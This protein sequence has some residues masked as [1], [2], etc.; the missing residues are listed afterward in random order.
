MTAGQKAFPVA[1]SQWKFHQQ[2]ATGRWL[3][4]LL[5]HHGK[6]A[7]DICLIR[8]VHTDAI[9]HD[10][11]IT[12]I[13]TGSEQPGRPC[14]GSWVTYGIGSENQNLPAFIVLISQG[15]GNKSDQPLF[16][17]LWGVGFLPSSYQGVKFRSQGDPVLFIKNPDGL[18]DSARREMLDTLKGLNQA[19]FES[20]GDPEIE[21]RIAQYEMALPD[22]GE[23]AGA[24]GHCARACRDF[25]L[26]GGR[27]PQAGHLCCELSPRA[28]VDRA[29]RPFRAALSSRL[30]SARDSSRNIFRCNARMSIRRAPRWCSISSSGGLLDE[31]LVIWG[32]EFGRPLTSRA[33]SKPGVR[34]RPSSTLLFRLAGWRRDQ[35]GPDF[36]DGRLLL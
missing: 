27:R 6:I 23:R 35:T 20:V 14:M 22:A 7:D 21:T 33:T 28:P 10:P 19:A 1:A 12:F 16:S 32:G 13:Q 24:D 5:P 26:Y 11:A 3:S 17:R 8:S 31:T 18:D 34:A 9:N 4:E 36:G 25:E 30:G 15:S 29:R 2:G